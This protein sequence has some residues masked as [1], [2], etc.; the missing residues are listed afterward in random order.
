MPV[1]VEDGAAAMREYGV[2]GP[3]HAVRSARFQ[4]QAGKALVAARGD[5][6]SPDRRVDQSEHV[7]FR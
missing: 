1:A 6:L 3:V 2:R 7:P 4:L 5:E